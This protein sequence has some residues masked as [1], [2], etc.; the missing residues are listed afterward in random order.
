[1]KKIFV[2]KDNCYSISATNSTTLN[3]FDKK[4]V[5]GEQIKIVEN[6]VW[7]VTRESED[8]ICLRWIKDGY[9]N[10]D[11]KVTFNIELPIFEFKKYFDEVDH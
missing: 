9:E 11:N 7:E 6:S 3:L 1:M 10:L 8:R 2:C 4:Y 5:D